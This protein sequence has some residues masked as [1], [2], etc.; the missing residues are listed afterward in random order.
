MD[1]ITEAVPDAEI[2]DN[3]FD[4]YEEDAASSEEVIRQWVQELG[5]SS[6]QGED[7]VQG[8]ALNLQIGDTVLNLP[9]IL[10]QRRFGICLRTGL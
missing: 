8:N 4:C 1:I 5:Y 6:A 7:T 10:Q 3:I 9:T 2:S